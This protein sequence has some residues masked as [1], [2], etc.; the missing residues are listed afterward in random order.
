MNTDA[1][2]EPI[3]ERLGLQIGGGA[4][5]RARWRARERGHTRVSRLLYE[6]EYEY[7]GVSSQID[8]N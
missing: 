4:N 6:Y 1:D 2:H 8:L 7:G 5:V 3:S